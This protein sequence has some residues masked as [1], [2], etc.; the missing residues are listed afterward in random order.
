[1]SQNLAGVLAWDDPTKRLELSEKNRTPAS[2]RRGL[3]SQ[4][5]PIRGPFPTK[6]YSRKYKGGIGRARALCFFCFFGW[7]QNQST[8]PAQI[9]PIP[10]VAK[11][12]ASTVPAARGPCL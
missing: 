9:P 4:Q 8:C 3:G 10:A 11:R 6:T 5:P 2:T 1:M 12:F 7:D